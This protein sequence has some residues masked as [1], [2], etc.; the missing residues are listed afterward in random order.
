MAVA[1]MASPALTA[2]ARAGVAGTAHLLPWGYQNSNGVTSLCYDKTGFS[3]AGAGYNGTLSEFGTSGWGTYYW[4]A[5]SSGPNGTKHN[6]TTY[7]GYRLLQNGYGYPGWHDNANGWALDAA[8]PSRKGSAAPSVT[9]DQNPIAG[10]IAQWN[11]GQNGHVAYVEAVTS[12]YIV[13][14]ADNFGSDTDRLKIL[15]TSPYMPDNFIHFKDTYI[16]AIVQWDGDTK[17]QKTAWRV[18]ADGRRH[19]LPSGSVYSCLVNGGVTGPYVLPSTVLDTVVPDRNY[20]WESCGADLNGDG[21]V[22]VFDLSILESDWGTSGHLGDINL[23][24]TVNATDL[25]ILLS[26]WGKAPTPV[27]IPAS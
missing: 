18:G 24:G 8:N 9:V 17:A 11:G 16:G 7:V 3:C 23:D 21:V 26:Q 12:T 25:S 27:V 5:G 22:N 10:S 4:S 14:T 15:R 6:C 19:W 13:I 20:S 2:P 1:A